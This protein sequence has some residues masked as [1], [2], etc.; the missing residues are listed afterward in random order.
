MSHLIHTFT[1]TSVYI[2][3]IAISLI[4]YAVKPFG[5]EVG[6]MDVKQSAVMPAVKVIVEEVQ[7]Q[8]WFWTGPNGHWWFFDMAVS[9]TSQIAL[10]A[11]T[12]LLAIVTFV[13]NIF[14]PVDRKPYKGRNRRKNKKRQR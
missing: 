1:E 3:Y 13:I 4:S 2:K 7:T 8:T 10:F 6:T 9:D 14:R 11:L 5:F 12:G